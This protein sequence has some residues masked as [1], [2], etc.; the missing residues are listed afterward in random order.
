MRGAAGRFVP[1]PAQLEALTEQPWWRDEHQAFAPSLALLSQLVIDNDG[2][3]WGDVAHVE[4]WDDA[5]AVL[6]PNAT[7]RYHFLTRARGWSKTTD[8]AAIVVVIMLTQ[9]HPGDRL[10]VVAADRD[11]GALLINAIKKFVVRTPGL[12]GQLQVS[13]Y[14]VTAPGDVVLE[15]LPADPAGSYGRQPAL[16][17]VD[18]LAQ[19]SDTPSSHERWLANYTACIKSPTPAS[20][21]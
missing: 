17:I 20:S 7:S 8:L 16:L 19:W 21:C 9:A 15:A 3:R 13:R 10:D 6:D 5:L 12:A 11:Q 1:E 14:E 4:Q 18:E 2:R